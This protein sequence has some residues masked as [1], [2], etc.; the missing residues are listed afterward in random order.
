M[1]GIA[2]DPSASF[3]GKPNKVPLLAFGPSHELLYGYSL[4]CKEDKKRYPNPQPLIGLPEPEKSEL[5][6]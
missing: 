3:S 6:C 1:S 5:P 2:E 4:G